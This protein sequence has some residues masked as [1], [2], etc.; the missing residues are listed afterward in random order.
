KGL[1]R[2]GL[3]ELSITPA[4]MAAR[5]RQLA[6]LRGDLERATALADR[7]KR[8]EALRPFVGCE[9]YHA[10]A[11]AF[12]GL[13]HCG[14]PAL[15]VLRDPSLHRRHDM[16]VRALARAGGPDTGPELVKLLEG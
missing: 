2:T 15:P 8:A 7:G 13:A 14:K 3:V 6:Q 16:V 12:E 5:V 9:L 10:R 4:E 11:N 1:D